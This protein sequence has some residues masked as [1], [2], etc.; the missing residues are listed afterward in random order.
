[1]QI[2]VD[3]GEW[4]GALLADLWKE[5]GCLSNEFLL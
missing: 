4:F 2:A 5:F 1:M 3:K